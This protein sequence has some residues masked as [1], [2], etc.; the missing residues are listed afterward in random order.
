[1]S[2]LKGIGFLVIGFVVAAVI[3]MFAHWFD[4]KITARVQWRVEH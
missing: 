4:R 3:G 2:I 1:M